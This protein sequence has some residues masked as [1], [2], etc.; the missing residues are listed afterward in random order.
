MGYKVSYDASFNKIDFVS[1]SGSLS[2]TELNEI[3]KIG[4]MKRIQTTE[5]LSSNTLILLNEQYYSKYPQTGFRI[6]GYTQSNLDLSFLKYLSNL[7]KLTIDCGQSIDNSF[8][9]EYLTK[10]KSL[11]INCYLLEDFKFLEKLSDTLEQFA[12]ETKKTSFDISAL[13]KFKKLKVL[14]LSGYKKNIETLV[15]LTLLES[16]MLKGITLEDLT[17]LNGIKNLKS[18]KIHRG[19]TKDFSG[20]YGNNS[21]TS[22]QIFRVTKFTDV[23]LIAN[24]PHLI[25][26]ELSQ[27]AHIEHLPNLSKHKALKHIS[28]NEMK[29]LT[30]LCQLEFV[31]NLESVSFSCCPSAFEPECIIP[32]L[33]NPSITECSFYTSSEKKNRQISNYIEATGKENKSNFMTVRNMLFTNR[34]EF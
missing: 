20:L 19:N 26:V 27:L 30:D 18:L 1:I 24:L 28:L 14:N 21:I 10:L 33:K 29:S 5:L 23:D 13:S 3:I 11:M 7:E 17:F 15:N 34:T 16:L 25:S 4:A 31:K 8:A 9:F 12:M 32:V 6:Y 2:K 22:L